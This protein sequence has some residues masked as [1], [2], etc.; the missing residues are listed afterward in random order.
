MAVIT[1]SERWPVSEAGQ[2]SHRPLRERTTSMS[3][4]R[5]IT[6][7]PNPDYPPE[8]VLPGVMARLMN[9]DWHAMT[10]AANASANHVSSDDRWTRKAREANPTLD[11]DQAYRLGQHL[12][13]AHYVRMGKL[14]AEARRLTRQAEDELEG[15]A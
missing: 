1:K 11:D 10:A 2:R 9:T 4:P 12:K 3:H 15:A 13:R 6:R 14:S 8:R 7:V 5:S